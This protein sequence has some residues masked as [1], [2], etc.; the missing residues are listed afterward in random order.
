MSTL[1]HEPWRELSPSLAAIIE[2]ELPSLRDEILAVIAEE[3]PEYARPLEGNF[4]RGLRLGVEEALRQFA[5]LIAEPDAGRAQSIEVY[6]GLGR[7]EMRE[8]RSLDALQAAYRVGARV[9]WRR[10]SSV[11]LEAGLE[12]TV[13]CSL[14]DAIFAYID[15]LSADSV[16]GFAQAQ[17]EAAGE[18]ERRRRCVLNALLAESVELG[19]LRTAA[20]DAGWK[21]PTAVA[22]LACDTGD[23]DKIAR[24]A[25]MDALAGTFDELG[26]IVVADPDAPGRRAELQ[27]ACSGRPAA[28]GPTQPL[29]RA[30]QSWERARSGIAAIRAGALEPELCVVSER[31]TEIA[32][33]DAREP[34]REL[35]AKALAPLG[36]LTPAARDRMTE[37]LRAYLDHRGNAPAMAD[38]LHVHPQTVRYRLK[39]L[40]D[41]FGEALDDPEA[42]FELET[43]VRIK[44]VRP[45]S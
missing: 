45:L 44:G 41:L 11:G 31:L 13:L 7:G 14:A 33:F 23:V 18:R 28:L 12:P 21:L 16:E 5:R 9:A 27:R 32:F 8:G 43:A 15:E 29:E 4:G 10:L 39:K 17:Q 6:R 26:C 22:V 20:A 35:R 30:R 36:D 37:T 1:Q 34:L 2:P 38:A 3:V 40:R 42:R 24:R 19:A 25:P